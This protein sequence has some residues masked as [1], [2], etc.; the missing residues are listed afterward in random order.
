[1]VAFILSCILFLKVLFFICRQGGAGGATIYA[2][3]GAHGKKS[4]SYLDIFFILLARE[5]KIVS[6]KIKVGSIA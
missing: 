1:M 6:K 5:I 3:E 4:S 2:E